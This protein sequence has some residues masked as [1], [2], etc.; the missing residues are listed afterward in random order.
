MLNFLTALFQ[1]SIS[2]SVI[3]LVYAVILPILSKR[4][5]EKWRYIAW[6]VITVGWIFPF[7]PQIELSTLPAKITNI[8]ISPIQSIIDNT[9]PSMAHVGDIVNDPATIHLWWIFALIWVIGV[10]SVVLYHAFRHGRFM[11]LVRRWGEPINDL[12]SLEILN[13][14]KLKLEINKPIRLNVCYSITSPMLIGLFQPVILLPPVEVAADELTLILKHELI[15]F[16]RHDLWYKALTLI[17]TAIHWF[18][19]IVY[20]MA[21]ETALQCEISCD[22]LVLQDADFQKRKQY[23]ETIIGVVRNGVKLQTALSTNFYGGERGM[24]NRIISIMDTKK[25]KGGI[26]ILCVVL[27]AII[28]TGTVFAINNATI[29][30]P[31]EV[32]NANAGTGTANLAVKNFNI[33]EA[34]NMGNY[35]EFLKVENDSVRY[36]YDGYWVRSLYDENNP[37][38]Q[39]ISENAKSIIYFNAVEDKD[40][41]GKGTPIY[42]KTVRNKDTNEIE[43]LVEMSEEEAWKILNGSDDSIVQMARTSLNDN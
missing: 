40:I 8:P 5:S 17:A 14:L 23:G 29:T 3:T 32:M 20:F 2:M 19:P 33:N 35:S 41:L 31:K 21:K 4:Y 7:R 28:G 36:Y 22:A 1:C 39:L 25:K 30:S 16:K 6:L 18:N 34:Y 43:K 24:K 13:N 12:E 27:I 9:M 15:H 37:D 10:V 42:L 11:W 26:I 38:A